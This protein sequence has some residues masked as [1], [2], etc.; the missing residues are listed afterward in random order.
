MTKRT[1]KN[2][3]NRYFHY[4]KEILNTISEPASFIDKD[5]RYVF[6]NS[7]FNKFFGKETDEIIGKTDIELWGKKNFEKQIKPRIDQCLRGEHVF[8]EYEGKMLDGGIKILEM[9]FYPHRKASRRIDGI[10]STVKDITTQKRAEKALK[11]S[12]ARLIELNATKDKLFSIIGHDLKGPLN[13]ITGFSELI[14]EGFETLPKESIREYNQ[15]IL[16]LSHSVSN[17]LENLLTWSRSQRQ[18]MTASP[19]NIA[20]YFIVEK[21]FSLY[22]QQALQKEITLKNEVPPAML[23]YADEEMITILVRNLISNA[24]KF[25]HRGGAVVVTAQPEEDHIVTEIRDTGVGIPDGGIKSLFRT[26]QNQ[27]QKGTEGEKGTGLGLVICKDL[28]EK[29]RGKIWAKSEPGQGSSFFFSIPEKN[30]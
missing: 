3:K 11:D 24:L 22:Y 23:I 27:P 5:Y 29:N 1:N 9:N 12:E 16:Q 21:C 13:N 15:L 14:E 26:N 7:A 10:I 18:K 28:I 20:L 30:H 6:I 25:S 17:L 19:Q 2:H 8:L 4:Q